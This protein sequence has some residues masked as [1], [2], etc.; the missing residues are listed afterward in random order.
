MEAGTFL[1][2]LDSLLL[3]IIIAAQLRMQQGRLG[4]RLRGEDHVTLLL[5]GDGATSQGDFHEGLNFA[6]V[7]DSPAIF[8]CQNNGYAISVPVEK[9]CGAKRLHRRRSPMASTVC[10]LMETTF[11]LF[12]RRRGAEG[13]AWRRSNIDRSG[14]LSSGCTYDVGR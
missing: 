1:R 11:L 9:R 10:G 5:F 12:I 6:A 2:E 14:Y 4:F 13:P 8:F 3:Q 7:Y